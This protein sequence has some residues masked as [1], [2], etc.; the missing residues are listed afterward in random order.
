MGRIIKLSED[1]LALI[2]QALV[3]AEARYLYIHM[4]ILNTLLA[5]ERNAEQEEQRNIA[6]FYFDKGCT[7][8]ELNHNLLNGGLDV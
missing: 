4:E 6:K 2:V 8:Q 7:C 1:Q 3:I 5:G